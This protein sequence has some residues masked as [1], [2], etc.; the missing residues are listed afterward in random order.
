MEDK[1]KVEKK[2]NFGNRLV[3]ESEKKG[4]VNEVFD[5][6][7][8]RYDLM[9]DLMSFCSHRLWKRILIGKLGLKPGQ[10]ALDLAGGT[11]D[12]AL[13]MARAVGD[14]GRVVVNDINGDMMKLGRRKVID[15]GHLHNIDFAQGDAEDICFADNSFEVAVVGFGIRN[16]TRIGRG[17]S[18]MAR[19]VKPGGRVACLEFS[20]PRSAL[21]RKAYD[22]YSFGLI[23]RIGGAVTSNSEA[24][25]YLAESIRKFPPQEE[26][27]LIMEEAGLFK[28]KYYNLFNGIAA[29]H[30]GYKV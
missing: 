18:E 8:E 24:Y 16:V 26:L 9:N 2:T 11:A 12:I 25:I 17:F 30:V 20:H 23:P 4:L 28:V 6:V 1:I 21:F 10:T 19:V 29:I 14:Y 7:Y 27:K 13:L 15:R 5:S 22:A 3:P